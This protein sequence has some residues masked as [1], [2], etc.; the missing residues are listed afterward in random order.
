MNQSAPDAAPFRLAIFPDYREEGWPSMDLCADML[1][2][3][4]ACDHSL[5][6]RA[7]RVDPLFRRFATRV[8][9]LGGR[10]FAW[11][12]DRLVN[13]FLSYPRLARRIARDFDFFHVVDHTYAQLV[14]ALPAARVGVFC[15]DLDAFRCLLEPNH[16]R[17]PRWF[18]ALAR[19]I[20]VGLQHAAVVF[21]GT[22]AVG[23]QIQRFGLVSPDRLV[24]APYGTALEYR[25]NR[26]GDRP[27][28]LNWAAD[29]A[30]RPW[31]VHVGSC[32]PRKRIDVLL[33]VV[34]AVRQVIPNI[35]LVKVGGNWSPMQLGQIVRLRLESAIVHP[36]DLTRL[37]LAEVYR[38]AAGVL[39]PSE[40]EGF[41]LPVIEALACG[42]AVVAADIPALREAG[43]PAV[44]Y[45]PVGD[46][47]VWT[48]A[49]LSMLAHESS[50][51]RQASRLA[52]ANR[53]SWF[54]QVQT[55][56]RAYHRLA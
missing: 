48:A 46:V 39:V 32:I 8:S 7:T 55:I 34:A 9:T 36:R 3:F 56:G 53:F 52:W 33:D 43:G 54:A 5:G 42:T 1:V 16:E 31:L 2:D 17:R 14:H 10:R 45:A 26:P 50:S 21:H 19:R 23:D 4:L 12:A 29:W 41:G 51:S 38:R 22:T 15:H 30:G 6:L 25:P 49:V 18:R 20:L 37:E 47:D 27:V 11:N 44:T 28:N 13:R 40:A 24:L 35:C